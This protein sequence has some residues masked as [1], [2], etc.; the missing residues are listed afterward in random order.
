MHLAD[1]RMDAEGEVE[2]SRTLTKHN[3]VAVGVKT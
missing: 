1:L 2:G 3:Q